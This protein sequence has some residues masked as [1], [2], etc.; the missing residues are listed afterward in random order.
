[1]NALTNSVT[2]SI[3]LVALFSAL[4]AARG[5]R[6]STLNFVYVLFCTSLAMVMLD[7][8]LGD[9][10]AEFRLVAQM[11]AG[12]TCGLFWLVARALFRAD[13]AIA[14]PHWL[15]VASIAVPSTL[16]PLLQAAQ[17][18]GAQWPVPLIAGLW[19]IQLLLSSAALVLAVW[20]GLNGW[21]QGLERGERGLRLSYFAIVGACVLVSESFG[22]LSQSPW[23]ALQALAQALCALAVLTLANV[24]VAYRNR[25]PLLVPPHQ[26][27]PPRPAPTQNDMALGARI[28]TVVREQSLFLQP[29]LKVATLAALLNAPDYKI[30]RAICGAL[31]QQNFNQYINRYRIAYAKRLLLEPQQSRSILL[32]GIDSGFASIGP[33][34]RA[35][36]SSVGITP[37][38]FRA[39][40]RTTPTPGA[41]AVHG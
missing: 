21:H 23:V 14:L 9:A 32:I 28:E 36:K 24:A 37:R 5:A 6:A 20:E 22:P 38:Q 8:A 25:H 26:A 3:A 34:N 2:L 31:G 12:G 16:S 13:R 1:M 35:F 4:W 11:A 10:W 17:S 19:N 41:T 39:Q 18:S 33:F 15:F 27:S 29:E 7:R 30:S 40:V